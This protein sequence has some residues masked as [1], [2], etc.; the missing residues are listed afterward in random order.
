[1]QTCEYFD[2]VVTD[3][4]NISDKLNRIIQSANKD[5]YEY[6]LQKHLMPR[7]PLI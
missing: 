1:V 5:Y 3:N 4:S 7:L 6:G 2:S